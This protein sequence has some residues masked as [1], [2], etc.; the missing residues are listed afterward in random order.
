MELGERNINLEMVA[1]GHAWWYR[2]Y[3][4][5]DG[6]LKAAEVESC[7]ERRGLWADAEP[8]AP[9]E[10]RRTEKARKSAANDRRQKIP[11]RP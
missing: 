4:P 7:K 2:K 6:K 9:W 5:K 10:W 11:A 1:E 8:V 3:A